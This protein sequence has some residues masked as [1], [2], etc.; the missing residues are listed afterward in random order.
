MS[1]AIVVELPL[2]VDLAL[3]TP[4]V[5]AVNFN[6]LH[7]LLHVMIQQLNLA[8]TL[9][10][11]RGRTSVC[12]NNVLTTT[13]AGPSLAMSEFELQG[14]A[15]LS[16]GRYHPSGKMATIS[17]VAPSPSA[18]SGTEFAKKGKKLEKRKKSSVQKLVVVKRMGESV[19]EVSPAS[20][21]PKSSAKFSPATGTPMGVV[22]QENFQSFA[23]RVASIEEH[24]RALEEL[25]NNKELLEAVRSGQGNPV[26]EMWNGISLSKRIEAVES[27]MNK[28]TS[29]MEELAKEYTNVNVDL[30]VVKVDGSKV[31][32]RD[33]LD[34]I[35][36]RI[37]DIEQGT[38]G[39]P[40][41]GGTSEATGSPSGAATPVSPGAGGAAAGGYQTT[42]SMILGLREDLNSVRQDVDAIAANMKTLTAVG[43][44]ARIATSGEEGTKQ[45]DEL[46]V[47]L[48]QGQDLPGADRLAALEEKLNKYSGMMSGMDTSFNKQMTGFQK[49]MADLE[50]ELGA[51]LERINSAGLPI[52][53]NQLG[54]EFTGLGELYEKIQIL[55]S[56]MENIN[57]TA[58][59]LM[60][61][62]E[63][64][65]QHINALLEQIE[66]LKTCKADKEDLED[67]LADKAD[68][69][70]VNRKVSHDQFD[71]ACDD[72]SRGLEEALSKLTQ[73]E[74][75]WQQ[76]LDD[77]QKEIENKLDKIEIS[78]L[79]DFVN[80][81]LK[82]LQDRLK[83]LASLKKDSEA[84]G[85]K[86]K[87]LRNVNCISCDKD[88]VMRTD[89][90]APSMPVQDSLPPNMSM[91]PYLTYELDAVRKQQRQLPG[92]NMYHF[93]S[94]IKE[95]RRL[96]KAYDRSKDDELAK[97]NHLCNRYCGGS[98]TVTTP[99]Q[100]VTR[101]GHF[102][103][104]WGPEAIQLTE[105]T[106]R[107]SDGKFYKSRKEVP[108][109]APPEPPKPTRHSV[110]VDVNKK[111]GGSPRAS[112]GSLTKKSGNVS[113]KSASK[114]KL[115]SDK[116][117][118]STGSA[119]KV[120]PASS[121]KGASPK[122]SAVQ[123]APEQEIAPAVSP[124]RSK[125]SPAESVTKA[126][127]SGEAVAAAAA[128]EE[129]AEAAPAAE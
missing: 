108:P 109:Q 12:I 98:H 125:T 17:E 31:E 123:E 45:M 126:Q 83:A 27:G 11:F 104:Q 33:R 87:L 41:L 62:R 124:K 101:M 30:Q 128:S 35:E 71:A 58:T 37:F 112:Q 82:A 36:K 89:E 84:A 115:E 13:Q 23:E 118:S 76:A 72:L 46:R 117:R 121:Q 86:I 9:V 4:Q 6:I 127:V 122:M 105:G 52:G 92:R 50:K 34:N 79:K 97:M 93:E 74:T 65:Q 129:P 70:L 75:L 22:S 14:P 69:H 106:I 28:L 114:T 32:L 29:V 68:H 120:S 38:V 25:P 59:A 63:Q 44:A 77:V 91:K 107:G 78:P 119:K 16:Q 51:I 1:T 95:D 103:N 67:A 8:D 24:L 18:D 3:G 61:D 20:V 7:S 81:K 15:E 56:D 113:P 10:E 39:R 102:L 2:L 110:D 54:Q 60:D 99:Q 19:D 57:S 90:P 47:Q 85:T 55:Q 96:K 43:D 21:G 5:G 40:A 64:R 116:K 26:A 94:A 49:Q 42:D 100:R 53:D 73:Q 80:N 111:P 66:F 48:S 88:V